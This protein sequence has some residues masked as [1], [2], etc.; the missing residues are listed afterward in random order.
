[1]SAKPQLDALT[2]ARGIAA[3]FVVA[4]HVR[5]AFSQIF[6]TEVI[7][8][9]AKG[10]LAVDLF[11][12]LSGFV[13]WLTYADAFRENGWRAVPDFMLRRI[14]RIYPL[15]FVMLSAT[16][17]VAI[18]LSLLGKDI[19]AEFAFTELPLHYL[20]LQNWGFTD[21]LAWNDPSWSISTEL[22]AYLFLPMLAIILLRRTPPFL[23]CAGLIG[24]LSLLLDWIFKRAGHDLLGQDITGLGLLRCLIEFT[25]GVLVCLIWQKRG[26]ARGRMILFGSFT[27]AI[28]SL[29]LWQIGWMRETLAVPIAFSCLLY[30]MA[31]TSDWRGNPLSAAWAVKLG[32]ISYATYLAHFLIWRLFKIGFVADINDI[33]LG[34]MTLFFAI[35]GGASYGL[36]HFIE[37]P[38]RRW[39]QSLIHYMDCRASLAKTKKVD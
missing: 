10:Y 12:I 19:P 24:V 22:G 6:P 33:G 4:Y 5:A 17:F 13:M 29:T 8:L 14:A 36:Y 20:L 37:Q 38:G 26:E 23:V 28:L 16:V 3:W 39:V 18:S 25:C 9:F 27:L 21:A 32:M 35:V 30:S 2:G 34:T 15:H 7:A 11:F 1:M 31:I